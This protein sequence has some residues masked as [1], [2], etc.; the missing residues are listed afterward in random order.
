MG[1]YLFLKVILYTFFL[2]LLIY[3]GLEVGV[4]GFESWIGFLGLG[5]SLHGVWGLRSHC[6]VGPSG[7]LWSGALYI[8]KK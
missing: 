5:F 3:G 2:L 4:L 6:G 1:L 8:A 7:F